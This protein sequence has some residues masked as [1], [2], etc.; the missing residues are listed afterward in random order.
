MVAAFSVAAAEPR[1]APRAAAG[2]ARGER[3]QG[4][5]RGL[6]DPDGD[7]AGAVE[8][9]VEDEGGAAAGGAVGAVG[10]GDAAEDQAADE[11]VDVGAEDGVVLVRDP[12]RAAAGEDEG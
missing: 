6:G 12:G 8:V 9:F 3:Q 2:G 11:L 1:V 10:L 5:R 7:D 4:E